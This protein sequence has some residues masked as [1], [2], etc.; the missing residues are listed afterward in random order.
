MTSCE[1]KQT[2][3][4]AFFSA[5][6]S[7]WIPCVWLAIVIGMN[8]IEITQVIKYYELIKDASSEQSG[9]DSVA[10]R[11]KRRQSNMTGQTSDARRANDSD[12]PL[13]RC[14]VRF[15]LPWKRMKWD[16]QRQ[17]E[18]DMDSA[19][20]KDI[21][22]AWVAPH[23]KRGNQFLNDRNEVIKQFVKS[24]TRYTQRNCCI[25]YYKKIIIDK[26]SKFVYYEQKREM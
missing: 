2:F 10:S 8:R 21:S 6:S 4:A 23:L 12:V 7:C 15:A 18:C 3:S 19:Q 1:P 9:S 24:K 13:W 11:Q 17:W 22:S 14:F 25:K 16:C 5:A 20:W 26:K